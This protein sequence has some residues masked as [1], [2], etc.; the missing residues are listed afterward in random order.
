[1][2]RAEKVRAKGVGHP[3]HM[4]DPQQVLRII[5]SFIRKNA[6]A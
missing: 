4:Q 3:L 1:M 6:L 5:D 2:K